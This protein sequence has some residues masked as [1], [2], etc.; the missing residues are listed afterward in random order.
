[1]K[2]MNLLVL[3]VMVVCAIIVMCVVEATIDA[4]MRPTPNKSA[5]TLPF[6]DMKV[7]TIE[8]CEYFVVENSYRISSAYSFSM[9]HK[10]NC[11]NVIHETNQTH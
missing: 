8:G 11:T 4:V 6:P 10:G 3:V 5:G 7:M 2:L 9:C 1:M